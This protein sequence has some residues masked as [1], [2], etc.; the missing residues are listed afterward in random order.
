MRSRFGSSARTRPWPPVSDAATRSRSGAKLHVGVIESEQRADIPCA[1]RLEAPPDEL[2]VLPHVFSDPGPPVSA[3]DS[4]R[5]DDFRRV[6]I[7]GLTHTRSA[8]GTQ[9]VIDP[10]ASWSSLHRRHLSALCRSQLAPSRT[11]TSSGCPS[12]GRPPGLRTASLSWL[13]QGSALSAALIEHTCQWGAG[14]GRTALDPSKGGSGGA[15]ERQAGSQRARS[16]DGVGERVDESAISSSF[17]GSPSR[18]GTCATP[19]RKLS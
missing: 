17:A 13:D 5:R 12:P 11:P 10:W 6:R 14:A 18:C 19:S 8:M 16:L 3:P 2:K 9:A 1:D 4:D 7:T 15:L